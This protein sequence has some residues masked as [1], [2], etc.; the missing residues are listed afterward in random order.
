MN[1][2]WSGLLGGD[3][4]HQSKE[5]FNPKTGKTEQTLRSGIQEVA[6]VNVLCLA[7]A[8]ELLPQDGALDADRTTG[9]TG[10]ING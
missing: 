9:E 6:G 7:A 4:L 2:T 10:E 5:G 1:E 8:G 3:N